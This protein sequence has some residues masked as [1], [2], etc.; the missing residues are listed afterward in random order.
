MTRTGSFSFKAHPLSTD[1]PSLLTLLLHSTHVDGGGGGGGGREALAHRGREK[2]GWRCSRPTSR[3]PRTQPPGSP[4]ESAHTL[5]V[6]P[7]WFLSTPAVAECGLGIY[8]LLNIPDFELTFVSSN[9]ASQQP[10]VLISLPIKSCIYLCQGSSFRSREGA[11]VSRLSM[12][13]L[14]LGSLPRRDSLYV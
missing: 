2:G 8:L 9:L 13:P 10:E 14:F 12:L 3:R 5:L 7:W 11:P 1:S 6:F 4:C